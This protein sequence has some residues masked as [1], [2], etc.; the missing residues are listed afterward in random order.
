MGINKIFCYFIAAI[1][2]SGCV[3]STAM[4]G[5]AITIAS[6]GNISQAGLSFLTNKAVEEET[7]MNTVTFV[8]TKIEE[9]NSKNRMRRGIK[10]ILDNNFEKTRQKLISQDQSNIFK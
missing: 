10:E 2:L 1:L 8:S 6:T 4:I 3:Q 9:N 7:G 5:P